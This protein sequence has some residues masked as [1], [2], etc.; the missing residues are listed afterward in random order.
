MLVLAAA[1]VWLAHPQQPADEL[2][3]NLLRA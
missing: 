2:A 3:T 1:L